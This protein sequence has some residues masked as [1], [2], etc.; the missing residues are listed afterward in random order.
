METPASP[1]HV[2][3]RT[4]AQPLDKSVYCRQPPPLRPTGQLARTGQASGARRHPPK[5]GPSWEQARGGAA[6]HGPPAGTWAVAVGDSHPSRGST[7]PVIAFIRLL[8]SK[9]A[10]RREGPPRGW[11][12]LPGRS[13]TG[14]RQPPRPARLP[15]A[16]RTAVRDGGG[17][18]GRTPGGPCLGNPLEPQAGRKVDGASGPSVCPAGAQTTGG[19]GVEAL[20]TYLPTSCQP[21][22]RAPPDTPQ[23]KLQAKS[24]RGGSE[25]AAPFNVPTPGRG[26]GQRPCWT[27]ADLGAHQEAAAGE[28]P[29]PRGPPRTGR[30]GSVPPFHRP[31]RP[32]PKSSARRPRS[33][34][35]CPA[36]GPG[37]LLPQRVQGKR[38]AP[39][40]GLAPTAR[41][42]PPLGLCVR[43]Y[44]CYLCTYGWIAVCEFGMH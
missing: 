31:P 42:C 29:G 21:C 38:W 5:P 7:L 17:A 26:P 36:P 3:V 39:A 14:P 41:A 43:L 6:P 13:P 40:G 10:V 32:G 24:R 20:P 33:T 9:A 4:P 8:D 15:A 22:C 44:M 37:L 28:P 23:D 34:P 2:Q 18:R 19:H 30:H 35:C 12:Q 16:P 25:T 11:A 27:P 1:S